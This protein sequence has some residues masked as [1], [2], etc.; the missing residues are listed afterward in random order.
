MDTD[1]KMK[2]LLANGTYI[3]VVSGWWCDE[4]LMTLVQYLIVNLP[5]NHSLSVTCRLFSI[6][7]I[8]L[9]FF[10]LSLFV[11]MYIYY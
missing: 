11:L 10:F 6:I 3:G 5:V 1:A 2:F 9:I 8:L 4:L 7:R